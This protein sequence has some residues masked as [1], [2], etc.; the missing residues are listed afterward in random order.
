MEIAIAKLNVDDP[1]RAQLR[2]G[3]DPSCF[4]EFAQATDKR[5]G[6]GGGCARV[7]CKMASEA[8]VDDELPSC[9]WFG[10][11]K[12]TYSLRWNTSQ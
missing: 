8:G 12:K 7:L 11:L 1:I 6:S 4:Q 5:G 2:D 10:Q 9:V 3:C